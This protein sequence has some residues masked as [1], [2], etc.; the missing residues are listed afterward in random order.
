MR[1][2]DCPA[3]PSWFQPGGR[4]FGLSALLGRRLRIG[5]PGLMAAV[6]VEGT[7][8]LTASLAE[9]GGVQF[10]A[11][12]RAAGVADSRHRNA[13]I[14]GGYATITGRVPR[15]AKG[16]MSLSPPSCFISNCRAVLRGQRSPR[17]CRS[18]CTPGRRHAKGC[19]GRQGQVRRVVPG[20]GGGPVCRLP[21][22][23]LLVEYVSQGPKEWP[24]LKG[25]SLGLVRAQHHLLRV[26]VAND[27]TQGAATWRCRPGPEDSFLLPLHFSHLVGSLI[28]KPDRPGL[29]GELKL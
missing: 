5:V 19:T 15:A 6:A 21:S 22:T 3:S 8:R 7:R 25:F 29:W 24:T 12:F 9:E 4:G 28:E 17:Q 27:D 26:C 1:K 20:A 14:R 10:P 23:Q 11:T 13:S 18:T 2:V 16:S